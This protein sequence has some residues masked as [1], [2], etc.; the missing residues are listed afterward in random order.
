[1][2]AALAAVRAALADAGVDR[3]EPEATWLVEAATGLTRAEQVLERARVLTADEAE[4][5]TDWIA[6]RVRRDPLQLS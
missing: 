2:G 6:R 5:L 1:M 4:R 3:P